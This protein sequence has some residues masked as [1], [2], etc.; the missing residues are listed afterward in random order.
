[1]SFLQVNTK[2]TE[3]LYG[4][5]LEYAEIGPEDIVFD[6]YSGIGTTSLFLAQKAKKVVPKL[7][8]SE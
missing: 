2:Q 3:I 6:I 7:Y 4:K 1:V 5:A 8:E